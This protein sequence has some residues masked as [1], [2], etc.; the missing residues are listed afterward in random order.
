MM[1]RLAQ[2]YQHQA[3]SLSD[4]LAQMVEPIMM[5]IMG[6]VVGGLVLAMYLPIFQLGSVLQ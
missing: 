6:I 2:H 3:N 5:V 4:A 1:S